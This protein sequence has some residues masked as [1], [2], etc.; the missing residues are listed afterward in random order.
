MKVSVGARGKVTQRTSVIAGQIVSL[1]FNGELAGQIVSPQFNSELDNNHSDSPLL[2]EVGGGSV[3][4][5]K[6][7]FIGLSRKHAILTAAWL[8]VYCV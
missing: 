1:Q 5:T 8:S 6:F 7:V 4:L 3:F 2:V